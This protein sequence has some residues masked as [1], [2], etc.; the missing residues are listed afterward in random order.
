MSSRAASQV[1]IK[2]E[3]HG[4]AAEDTADGH[5]EQVSITTISRQ[6]EELRREAVIVA[7]FLSSS[8]F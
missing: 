5:V 3:P 1:K 7:E 4:S 2:R 6:V 8:E